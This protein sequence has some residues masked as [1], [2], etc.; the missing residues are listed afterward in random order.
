MWKIR[1]PE[2]VWR[3]ILGGMAST[4]QATGETLRPA[5]RDR[6]GAWV[7]ARHEHVLAAANDP[8]T[9]SS[10]VSRHLNIP[11]G[12]DGEEHA[13]FR[14][15]VERYMNPQRVA[16]LEGRFREIATGLIGSLPRD[17]KVEAVSGIG[18]PFAV[19]AQSTWLGW[20][21]DI[22]VTLLDWMEENRAASRSGNRERQAAV[23]E[24]FNRIIGSLVEARLESGEE[25]GDLTTELVAERVNGRPLAFGE[26]VSILRNWT[27]GDLGSIAA[28]IGVVICHLVNDPELQERWRHQRPDPAG[29]DR[30]ID[31]MLRIEDPFTASRRVTTCPVEIGGELIPAGEPVRL[32][33]AEANRDPEVTGDPDA[34]RPEKNAPRN[35]VY[36]A[37]PHV[38]PGRALATLEIRVMIEE[39]LDAT[40]GLEPDP[41]LSPV[42]ASPPQGGF[43][44]VPL[45]L[46][47]IA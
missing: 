7:L 13:R 32:S 38:C 25:P 4:G 10:R 21:A 9:F 37:G 36:G 30:E 44:A 29:L 20:P 27:A 2:L 47:A 5:I 18:S 42:R 31:E 40:A 35:L 26:V 16:G 34:F 14:K 45:R 33:W 24:H 28:C 3:T 1:N 19:R 11:N 17:R 23:A 39:L 43:R 6:T 12:M 15:L 41:D 8:R 46:R 22:E